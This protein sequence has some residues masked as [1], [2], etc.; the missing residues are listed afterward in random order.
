MPN[1][2]ACHFFSFFPLLLS[3]FFFFFFLS[4]FHSSPSRPSSSSSVQ[5]PHLSIDG[6]GDAA[7]RYLNRGPW[8]SLARDRH[9]NFLFSS[10]LFFVVSEHTHTYWVNASF[11]YRFP[12]SFQFE[13]SYCLQFAFPRP[14]SEF[15]PADQQAWGRA[16]ADQVNGC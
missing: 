1:R 14:A 9:P 16:A 3:P 15:G 11:N 4:F 5:L 2:T 8:A 6:G 10:S 12:K 7:S 13:A